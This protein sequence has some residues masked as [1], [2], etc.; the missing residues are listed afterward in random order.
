MR[1]RIDFSFTRDIRV[2]YDMLPSSMRPPLDVQLAGD[3]LSAYDKDRTWGGWH[4]INISE[5]RSMAERVCGFV[6]KILQSSVLQPV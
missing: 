2:L 1:C 5:T 4:N 3:I 6:D